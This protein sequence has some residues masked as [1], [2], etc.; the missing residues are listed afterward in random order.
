MTVVTSRADDVITLLP[1]PHR[2]FVSSFLKLL[3]KLVAEE[4]GPEST[5]VI[6]LPQTGKEYFHPWLI[7]I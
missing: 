6:P 7:H 3:C 1:P 4:D 2:S 5:R